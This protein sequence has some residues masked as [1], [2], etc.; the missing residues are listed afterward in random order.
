MGGRQQLRREEGR[1]R[2]LGDPG[3]QE[4][5]DGKNIPLLTCPFQGEM[6]S[7]SGRQGG[8]LSILQAGNVVLPGSNFTQIAF[9]YVKS[10]IGPSL[11]CHSG[12]SANLAP[13]GRHSLPTRLEELTA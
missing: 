5:D 1:R 6:E 13:S 10:L 11:A 12:V 8:L 3:C 7:S 4:G 9:Y 2:H